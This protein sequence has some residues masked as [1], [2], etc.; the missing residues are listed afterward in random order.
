LARHG[1]SVE[2]IC[3]LGG[4]TAS[5]AIRAHRDAKL[6]TYDEISK[7]D[8]RL[9]ISELREEVSQFKEFRDVLEKIIEIRIPQCASAWNEFIQREVMGPC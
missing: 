1:Y 4:V 8:V 6:L 3:S 5:I 7:D 9:L 2:Q